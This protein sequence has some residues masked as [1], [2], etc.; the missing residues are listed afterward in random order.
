MDKIIGLITTNYS[1]KHP[2]DLTFDRPIAALPYGGRYRLVDFALSNMVNCGIRTVGVI[3]PSNYRSIIDHISSGKDWMLDRKNGGLFLLPGSA[4]GTSRTGARFLIRDL[5]NNKL[6]LDR[7]TADYVICSASN[8]VYNMD[9]TELV[10]SHKESQADITVLTTRATRD[11][12][13]L[14]GFKLD[15]DGR[16]QGIHHGVA[17]GDTSFMD[18]FII[19]RTMLESLLN[20][21]SSADYLDLFEA[22][23]GD[24][25]RLAVR[26]H[27]FSGY[28]AAL[29]NV[30]Y[31]FHRSM[32][33][34]NADIMSELFTPER[35]ILTKAHDTPP[36]MYKRGC[37][38]RNAIVSAGSIIHGTVSH[39]I[40]GRNVVVEPGATVSNAIVYQNCVIKSGARVENAI[41]DRNNVISARTE[42]RGTPESI[43]IRRKGNN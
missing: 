35:P 32:E 36:V 25:G 22:M 34:L 9:F 13:D 10:N 18:T 8:I 26:T 2:S 40:L 41:I 3:M 21:Y 15:D 6:F 28:S 11:E 23:T 30:E 33:L 4:F 27:D 19:K 39:S 5:V 20:W 7:S 17:F 14:M 43:W 12:D 24:F 42:L 31:Y 29:F 38:V 37:Y 16:V 1:S